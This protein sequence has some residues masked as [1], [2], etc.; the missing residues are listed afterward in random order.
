MSEKC[1][2]CGKIDEVEP[3]ATILRIRGMPYLCD[4]CLSEF[5]GWLVSKW[6][7]DK[8]NVYNINL[9]KKKGEKQH[10]TKS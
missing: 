10:G 2:N 3:C 1:F 8:Y 4:K 7:A 9:A 6:M 5:F